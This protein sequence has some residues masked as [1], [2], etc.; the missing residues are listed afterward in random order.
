MSTN[1]TTD[2]KLGVDID[3][4]GTADSAA[5]FALGTTARANS[6]QVAIYVYAGQA[7]GAGTGV[8]LGTAFTASVSAGAATTVVAALA[9]GEYGWAVQSDATLNTA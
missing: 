8:K 4:A 1:Y 3:G 9:A 2:G 6:N 5:Q 7:L